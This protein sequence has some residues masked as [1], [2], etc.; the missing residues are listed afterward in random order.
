MS[1]LLI[2]GTIVK[3]IVSWTSV[4]QR[5]YEFKPPWP[6]LFC[7][8]TTLGKLFNVHNYVSLLLSSIIWSSKI[9]EMKRATARCTN[10]ASAV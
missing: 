8:V 9:W 10:I 6:T 1:L 4:R 5:C 3:W 7:C 2:D